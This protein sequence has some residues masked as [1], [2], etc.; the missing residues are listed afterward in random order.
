MNTFS[1]AHQGISS[2]KATLWYLMAAL[3][4]EVPHISCTTTINPQSKHITIQ[5]PWLNDQQDPAHIFI[6]YIRSKKQKQ[7]Y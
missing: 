3:G 6:K 2:T 4:N 5:Y 1:T 7:T